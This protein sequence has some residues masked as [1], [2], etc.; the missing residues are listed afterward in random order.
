MLK[1]P[2]RPETGGQRASGSIQVTSKGARATVAIID[3]HDGG[4][5]ITNLEYQRSGPVNKPLLLAALFALLTTDALAFEPVGETIDLERWNQPPTSYWLVGVVFERGDDN[6]VGHDLLGDQLLGLGVGYRSTDV[7][8]GG[9]LLISPKFER[10][11]LL[12]LRGQLGLDLRLY[13][14]FGV[15]WSVGAG[16]AAELRLGDH[17]WLLYANLFE[18]GATVYETQTLQVRL[19]GG[20]RYLVQGDLLNTFLIDP[21]G[22]DNENAQDVL[23]SEHDRPLEGFV[24]LVFQ[25]SID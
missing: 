17:F 5:R 2:T 19:I 8:V 4:E 12:D 24:R 1:K 21:N 10:Q 20:L 3:L 16:I 6:V 25:R 23:D 18:L 22:F 13:R 9:R 14:R 11:S 7:E 15:E